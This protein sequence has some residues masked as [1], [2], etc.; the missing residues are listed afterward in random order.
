MTKLEQII[1]L[2]PDEELLSADG[3]EDSIIGVIYDGNAGFIN[4]YIQ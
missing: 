1:E 3:F 2:Y 4:L